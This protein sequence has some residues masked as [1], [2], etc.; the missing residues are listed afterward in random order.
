[1]SFSPSLLGH[2]GNITLASLGG[3]VDSSV[4]SPIDSSTDV[5]PDIPLFTSTC[6][7][8]AIAQ[9]TATGLQSVQVVLKPMV[10]RG[11]TFSDNHWTSYR[12]NYFQISATYA[13]INAQAS[14]GGLD[15]DSCDGEAISN[16]VGLVALTDH[17]LVPIQHFSIGIAARCM[18]ET[19][20]VPVDLIQR[21]AKRERGP[22]IIP[23]HIPCAPLPDLQTAPQDAPSGTVVVY[24]RLQFRSTTTFA[25]RRRIG[26]QYHTISVQLWATLF[27]GSEILV[28][29]IETAPL[30]VR[31]KSPRHYAEKLD[32]SLMDDSGMSSGFESNSPSIHSPTPRLRKVG[33]GGWRGSLMA[34]TLPMQQMQQQIK[35][36][37]QYQ[38]HQ[39]PPS[40]QLNLL[41]YGDESTLG[42]ISPAMS[43]SHPQLS[44]LNFPLNNMSANGFSEGYSSPSQSSGSMSQYDSPSPSPLLHQALNRVASPS[45]SM[46]GR[47]PSP[48]PYAMFLLSQSIQ[49][50][51]LFSNSLLPTQ[52]LQSTQ[53][54]STQLNSAQLNSAQLNSTQSLSMPSF[55]LLGMG[56][57]QMDIGNDLS[58]KLQSISTPSIDAFGYDESM[59]PLAYDFG[60][61]LAL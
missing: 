38:P 32:M 20:N 26:K 10:G 56:N 42:M 53:L 57:L 11:F 48:N 15:V 5:T 25:N 7:V 35:Q 46:N 58:N 61:A 27:D 50:N 37:L 14:F 8:N 1:M 44:F 9:Q 28:A 30:V 39:Q 19:D 49:P 13:I 47:S 3:D 55:D 34:K 31:S 43:E 33:D 45:P 16:T 17:G 2:P 21:T 24:E 18:D 23:T 12:R 6:Q 60:E 52:R 22:K 29:S 41:Q 4:A 36:H 51:E 40:R 54:N 59:K